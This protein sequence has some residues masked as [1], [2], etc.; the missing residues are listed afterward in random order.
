M[1]EIKR[2]KE[3]YVFLDP[4]GQLSQQGDVWLSYH[5]YLCLPKL[6]GVTQYTVL[7]LKSQSF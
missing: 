5:E 1:N 2:K 3:M 6:S 4:L 7:C